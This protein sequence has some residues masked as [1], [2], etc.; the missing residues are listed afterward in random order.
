MEKGHAKGC[1]WVGF[2]TEVATDDEEVDCGYGRVIKI[3]HSDE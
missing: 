3:S 2:S 1:D